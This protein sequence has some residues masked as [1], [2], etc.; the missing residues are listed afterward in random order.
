MIDREFVGEDW[1]AWLQSKK[2]P[3]V[4][5]LRENFRVLAGSGRPTQVKNCFRNLKLHE[6]REL[7]KRKVC[8]REHHLSAVRLP[9]CPPGTS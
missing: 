6:Y 7:G 4:M 3:Y 8:G 5:R 1:F 2:I 9:A